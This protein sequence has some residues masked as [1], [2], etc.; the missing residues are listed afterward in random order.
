MSRKQPTISRSSIVVEY[1]APTHIVT[2]VGLC[3]YILR[4]LCVF[5]EG[6][7]IFKCDNQSTL[8]FVTNPI[9]NKGS[10]H[11]ETDFHYIRKL[12][13]QGWVFKLQFVPTDDQIANFLIK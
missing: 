1:R 11:L 5:L 10:P 3:W 2:K 12:L 4:D 9:T 13:Q 8:F 7:P 6:A